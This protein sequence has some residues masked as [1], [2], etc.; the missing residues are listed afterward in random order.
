MET[1]QLKLLL[2][3]LIVVG[4][5]FSTSCTKTQGGVLNYQPVELS[6]H[7]LPPTTAENMS[8]RYVRD[9]E[10]LFAQSDSLAYYKDLNAKLMAALENKTSLKEVEEL[11]TPMVIKPKKPKFELAVSDWYSVDQLLTYIDSSVEKV[12]ASGGEVDGFRVYIGVFP[13]K[14]HGEK[15]NYLTTFITPTGRMGDAKQKGNILPLSLPLY[16]SSHDITAVDPLEYGSD[17]NPPAA[18]YPQ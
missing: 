16:A 9:M 12:E 7:K 10:I 4:S 14:G 13:K 18:S 1:N 8:K 15:D 17:G 2:T 3:S 6:K 11:K 5:L